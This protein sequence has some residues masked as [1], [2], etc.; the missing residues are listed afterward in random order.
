MSVAA[1]CFATAIPLLIAF[2]FVQSHQFNP[3]KDRPTTTQE[4]LNL[5][6]LIYG[7][8]FLFCLGLTAMLFD[9][10]RI[11]AVAFLVGCWLALR[12]FKRFA[13]S[14][15]TPQVSA[16]NEHAAVVPMKAL[17]LEPAN[18]PT[19]NTEEMQCIGDDKR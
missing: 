3:A 19:T 1:G 18:P 13:N 17:P 7:T 9:F 6:A 12:S 10:N 4:A 16:P 15:P 8:K 2:G 5:T 11:V 14:R